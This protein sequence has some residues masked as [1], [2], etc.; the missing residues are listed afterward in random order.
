MCL[1]YLTVSVRV[2]NFNILARPQ[3]LVLICLVIV[4]LLQLENTRLS[5]NGSKCKANSA[6]LASANTHRLGDSEK[7]TV[8]VKFF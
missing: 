8:S 2:L 5:M 3:L 4:T 6:L 7:I 1:R